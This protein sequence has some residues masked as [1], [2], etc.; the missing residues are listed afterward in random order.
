[1]DP[2]PVTEARVVAAAKALWAAEHSPSRPWP[3]DPSDD[4]RDPYLHIARVML[5]AA[6]REPRDEPPTRQH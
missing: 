6:D 2:T 1:M 3:D 5:E 4:D